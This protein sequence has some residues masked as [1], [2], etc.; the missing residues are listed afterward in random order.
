MSERCS[1]RLE[2]VRSDLACVSFVVSTR[3]AGLQELPGVGPKV[4]TL[5]MGIAWGA[6]AGI[7]V[8]THVRREAAGHSFSSSFNS[9]CV[10]LSLREMLARSV[11]RRDRHVS[12]VSYCIV[13]RDG[14]DSTLPFM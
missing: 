3:L 4:A 9:A 8:D 5:V 1:I 14:W 11:A 12:I 10:C 7:C 2:P 6:A 13:Y